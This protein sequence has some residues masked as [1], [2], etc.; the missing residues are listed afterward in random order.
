MNLEQKIYLTFKEKLKNNNLFISECLLF[1]VDAENM[2]S[3][4]SKILNMLKE[5]TNIKNN[6]NYSDKIYMKLIFST[7]FLEIMFTSQNDSTLLKS[8]L[9]IN[10]KINKNEDDTSD[11]IIENENLQNF[12]NIIPNLIEKINISNMLE[13]DQVVNEIKSNQLTE[14]PKRL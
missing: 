6:F 2:S 4:E 3:Y 14:K 12:I 8:F 13:K 9:M 11:Y 7:T 10:S 5:V 1:R